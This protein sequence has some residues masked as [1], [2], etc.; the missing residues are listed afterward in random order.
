MGS[1]SLAL[2]WGKQFIH[3]ELGGREEKEYEF[4]P[5]MVAGMCNASYSGGN[6]RRIVNLR[7]D[8]A[9][10]PKPKGIRVEHLPSIC[11]A[12][13][14]V[15]STEKRECEFSYRIPFSDEDLHD[16]AIFLVEGGKVM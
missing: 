6:G 16:G 10:K 3:I 12:L 2:R 1:Q 13:V 8:L 15:P 9:Q 7:Q 5:G 14:S 11:E 4:K